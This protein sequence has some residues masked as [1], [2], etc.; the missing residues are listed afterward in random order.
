[1][2]KEVKFVMSDGLVIRGSLEGNLDSDNLVVMLH[3]GGYDRHEQG[4]KEAKK[5]PETG[6]T[7]KVFYNPQGNYDYLTTMLKDDYCVLRIDQRNHGKSGKNVDVQKLDE[8]LNEFNLSESEKQEIVKALHEK[9]NKKISELA[10]SDDLNMLLHRPPLKDMSFVE[11]SKDLEEV[12]KQLPEVVGKSFNFVD[13]VGTCMGTV[14]LGLYLE[15][16]KNRENVNSITLFS[17][18]YTFD[19]SFTK[20]PEDAGLLAKKKQVIESGKQFRLGNAV[21]GKSTYDE[22]ARFSDEFI[23]N[24]KNLDIP[25][26]CIQGTSDVLVPEQEQLKLFTEVIKNR[27]GKGLSEVYYAEIEGVHCLYDSLYPSLVEVSDFIN[28][29]HQAQKTI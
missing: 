12:M 21:E 9:D 1:M 3:S 15:N 17:P 5:N 6:K 24:L 4:I 10:T 11:M 22:V 13:Y 27:L 2:N 25:T 16:E 26:Y 8:K 18:L 28:A 20:T 23:E 14:V 7:E 29:N 19:Y